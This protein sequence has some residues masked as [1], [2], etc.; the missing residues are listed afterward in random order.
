[1]GEGRDPGEGI[2][3]CQTIRDEGR[4]GNKASR[5]TSGQNEKRKSNKKGHT[6]RP[7]KGQESGDRP[8]G[9]KVLSP[10]GGGKVKCL[11]VRGAR[12]TVLKKGTWGKRKQ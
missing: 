2:G 4:G 5:K 12:A 9:G 8:G 6:V 3:N 7:R 10:F 11:I 1:L